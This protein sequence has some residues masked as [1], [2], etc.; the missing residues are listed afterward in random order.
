MKT[1]P[2]CHAHNLRQLAPS[3][4]LS[5]GIRISLR[6]DDPFRKLLGGD[7]NRCHWYATAEDRDT[8][9]AEMSR[10]HDYSRAGDRPALRFEKIS[11]FSRS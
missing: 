2:P 10:Q 6:A 4:P 11:R 3:T 7:W 1:A 5:Y 9:L 8:A